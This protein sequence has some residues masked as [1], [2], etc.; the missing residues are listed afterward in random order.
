M[1]LTDKDSCEWNL[2]GDEVEGTQETLACGESL[3]WLLNSLKWCAYFEW[4]SFLC[5]PGSLSESGEE[6]EEAETRVMRSHRTSRGKTKDS[7]WPEFTPKAQKKLKLEWKEIGEEEERDEGESNL[8]FKGQE[9]ATKKGILKESLSRARREKK[10]KSGAKRVRFNLERTDEPSSDSDDMYV[11][12]WVA[13]MKNHD[14]AVSRRSGDLL[15]ESDRW[16][17][18]EG[19]EDSDGFVDSSDDDFGVGGEEEV[20]E[21]EEDMEEEEADVGKEEE[22]EDEEEEEE[23]EGVGKE[24]EGE[25]EDEEEEEEEKDMAE[26]EE[27]EEEEEEKEKEEEEEE[28]E[29]EEK[30]EEKEEEEEE[31]EEKEASVSFHDEGVRYIPPHSKEGSGASGDRL[32]GRVSEMLRKK[33]QGL[34]NR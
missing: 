26:E 15:F 33:V 12:D 24:E 13:G 34:I 6:P 8:C 10:R 1:D 31:A 25:D 30:E 29:E 32:R 3:V 23:E 14:V 18:V 17:N 27:E 28:E 11:Q 22:W 21:E 19:N 5:V 16:D 20:E 2:S 9:V 7:S 4:L